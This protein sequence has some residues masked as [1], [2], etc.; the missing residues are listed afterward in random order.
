MWF[1]SIWIFTLSLPWTLGAE[2]FMRHLLDGDPASNTLSWRWVAGLHTQGKAYA[3]RAENIALYTQGRFH[4]KGLNER[5]RPLEEEVEH[6]LLPLTRSDEPPAGEAALLVH[7]DD[8][9]PESLK[10]GGGRIVRVG[11]LLAHASGA[12]EKVQGADRE[13][14]A[15]TLARAAAHFGCEAVIAEPDWAG[16]L[17]IITAWAPLGPSA[18]VL[19][20]CRRVRRSWDERAWPKATRGYFKLRTA[21]P[22]LLDRAGLAD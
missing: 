16:D 13:A 7:L 18:A 22:D 4:P 2:F 9:N 8:L 19:P 14:M 6:A 3:A 15:D 17:P 21:I 10:F 1:A 5:P 20:P 12:S 11:G